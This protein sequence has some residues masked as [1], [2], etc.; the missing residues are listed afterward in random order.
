MCHQLQDSALFHLRSSQRESV[1][2]AQQFQPSKLDEG[3]S[4]NVKRSSSLVLSPLASH[5]AARLEHYIETRVTGEDIPFSLN[6]HILTRLKKFQSQLRHGMKVNIAEEEVTLL[7]EFFTAQCDMEQIK[8]AE[9]DF[10]E[11][12]TSGAK[13][14]D[15][16][17]AS[18]LKL[19]R[20]YY[21]RAG[22]I[23]HSSAQPALQY[24]KA[25][26]VCTDKAAQLKT[27]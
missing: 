18:Y 10:D 17:E 11:H 6:T 16:Y 1:V 5:A 21:Q 8:T 7:Q 4:K 20:F 2:R 13:G 12:D 14:E 26:Y 25:S 9:I 22:A 27:Y 15:G 24:Y 19:E 3:P 23:A